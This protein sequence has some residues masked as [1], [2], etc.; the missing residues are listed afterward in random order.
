MYQLC[1]FVLSFLSLFVR[2]GGWSEGLRKQEVGQ[3]VPKY[4]EMSTHS[5]VT[6]DFSNL[7]KFENKTPIVRM[8][9]QT[10]V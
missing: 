8:Y 10:T 6:G 3:G 7:L 9:N 5:V 1:R 2:F 4:P